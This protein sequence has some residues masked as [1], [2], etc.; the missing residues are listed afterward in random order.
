MWSSFRNLIAGSN[1]HHVE[2]G[3]LDLPEGDVEVVD[4]HGLIEAAR[5]LR[6][7]SMICAF[8]EIARFTGE[9]FPDILQDVWKGSCCSKCSQH[10]CSVRMAAIDVHLVDQSSLSVTVAGRSW[11]SRSASVA[12]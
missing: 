4:G 11:S 12:I 9:L 8:F 7:P 6:S 2:D 1:A 5:K 10:A 3:H